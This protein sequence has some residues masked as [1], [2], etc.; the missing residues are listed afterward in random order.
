MVKNISLVTENNTT[1]RDEKPQQKDRRDNCRHLTAGKP[2]RASSEKNNQCSGRG[3]V[4]TTVEIVPLLSYNI[5]RS[6]D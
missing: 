3:V 6:Q 2:L 4:Q 1:E 5:N